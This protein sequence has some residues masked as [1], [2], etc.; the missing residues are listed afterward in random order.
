MWNCCKISSPQY[1]KWPMA[2]QVSAVLFFFGVLMGLQS[3]SVRQYRVIETT[4]HTDSDEYAATTV[5]ADAVYIRHW[6]W[7]EKGRLRI[8][9]ENASDSI[10]YVDLLESFLAVDSVYYIYRADSS[11][12]PVYFGSCDARSTLDW[13]R[14]ALDQSTKEQFLT[15]NPG[16]LMVMSKFVLYDFMAKNLNCED[17]YA[18]SQRY[19][20]VDSPVLGA[21]GVG[22]LVGQTDS[23]HTVDHSFYVST[24]RNWTMKSPDKIYA[25]ENRQNQFY[26]YNHTL[27]PLGTFVMFG[28]LSFAIHLGTV[29]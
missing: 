3:C 18:E 22:Y 16:E 24:M 14:V 20:M 21:H 12:P 29:D 2:K 10:I 26:I 6:C 4:W 17:T 11:S 1:L 23:L 25:P 9:I 5:N 27:H 7:G 8:A 19:S 15:I 28:L 13:S